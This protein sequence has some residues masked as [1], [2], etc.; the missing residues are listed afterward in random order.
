MVVDDWDGLVSVNIKNRGTWEPHFIRA[1]AKLVKEGD[2][3]LNIGSHIGL[4]MIVL[5]QGVGPKGKIYIFEP[6]EVTY[7][8][9]VKNVYLNQL[10]D[11]TT[12]YKMGTSNAYSKGVSEMIMSNMGGSKINTNAKGKPADRPGTQYYEIVVDRADNVL[13][14]DSKINFALIDPEYME[15]EVMEGL[16]ETISRSPN[17]IIMIEWWGQEYINSRNVDKLKKT[18]ELLKELERRG[19]KFYYAQFSPGNCAVTFVHQTYEQ[20]ME[21]R[22]YYS[23]IFYVPKHIDPNNY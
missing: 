2:T 20:A 3:L 15:F 19:Y 9:L 11:I 23:D 6:I 12:A 16:M 21:S 10:E 5:G 17:M 7:A 8:M 22:V 1:M 18:G 4:E 13:P 14:K